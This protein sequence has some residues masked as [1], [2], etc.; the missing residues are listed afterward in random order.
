M[1]AAYQHLRVR[2][3]IEQTRL[4]N[5]GE[6]VGLI[7]EKLN[8]PSR[9]LQLNRN[10]II[11]ILLEVQ[12]LFRSCVA[13]QD[14]FDQLVPQKPTE[15]D[16]AASNKDKFDRRFPKGTNTMLSKTLGFLEKASE[17][18]RRLQWAIVK[19]DRFEGLVEKLIH[20]NTSIE[21]LLDSTAIDQL[22]MLQQQTYMAML[23][24]N[25]DVVELKE[26]SLALQI[27]TKEGNQ[28]NGAM[29]KATR[30]NI[31]RAQD[32]NQATFSRLADFKAQQMQLE[33]NPSVATLEPIPMTDIALKASSDVR[34]EASYRGKRIWIEWKPYISGHN[35]YSK[36]ILT[37]EDRIKKLAILL[38]SDNKPPQF[39][40]PQC[41]GYFKHSTHKRYGFLYA[42]PSS[43]PPKTPPTSLLNLIHSTSAKSPSVTKRIA[44]A[45]AVARCLMYLHSV[46][47]LHKG[48]RSNNII[49]FIPPGESPTYSYPLIAGFEY[50]R[51]DFPDE[52]TEPPPEH[53]E[54]DIYRHPA[55]LAR[56]VSR[57]QKSHDIYSLGIVL[58]EIAYW[59]PIDEV[60]E[61]PKEARAARSRVKKVRD[62][63]LN[64]EYLDFVE[65]RVGEVYANAVRKCLAGGIDLGIEQGAHESDIEVGARIQELFA[66][67]VV[68]K[69]RDVK[70]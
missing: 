29:D 46:N 8:D 4:L 5:W 33:V 19:K 64:G 36:W 21:A 67:D 10:L 51:P 26:I 43:V 38:G 11:D 50:A 42:K 3:R 60:M 12:T 58:V 70:V 37:I 61:V 66:A 54:H 55:I 53:S 14:K 30:S 6:K 45:H 69:L 28:G 59:K 27:R 62:L 24:L 20:Y 52:E 23:Q 49:F 41:L 13:I 56:T 57:S 31:G 48:L 39:N 32:S 65:G 17:V 9:V 7:E 47:W 15:K 25:S 63:L 44:L 22:Q 2:L 68:G 16:M 1:P 35:T 40:A 18:P 34:S